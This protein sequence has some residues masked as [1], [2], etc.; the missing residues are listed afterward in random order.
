MARRTRGS[1]RRRSTWGTVRQK[2]SGNF[3]ASYRH[4]G[5]PGVSASAVYI[6]PTTFQTEGDARIW[7]ETERRLIETG[8]WTPPPNA[9]P[10]ATAR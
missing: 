1:A 10:H 9:R 2:A 8:Q 6:A 7:L 5:I 4:G 3:Q